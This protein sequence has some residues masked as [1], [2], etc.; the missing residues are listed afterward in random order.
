MM[1]LIQE[2][3]LKKHVKVDSFQGSGETNYYG[4]DN[5]GSLKI[6][7]GK[8]PS[9]EGGDKVVRHTLDTILGDFIEGGET[10]STRR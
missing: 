5:I 7:K 4:H 8:E 9:K 10:R 3:C 2:G 1:R 6:R